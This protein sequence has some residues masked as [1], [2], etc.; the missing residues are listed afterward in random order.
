MGQQLE[1]GEILFPA[2]T[3]GD[4]GTYGSDMFAAKPSQ[5]GPF[6]MASIIENQRMCHRRIPGD[7]RN[8]HL[9]ILL[10]CCY[11][12]APGTLKTVHFLCAAGVEGAG[13]MVIAPAITLRNF[14]NQVCDAVEEDHMEEGMEEDLEEAL[15]NLRD[16]GA[17]Y[18]QYVGADGA[19]NEEYDDY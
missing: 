19:N 2:V 4:G 10:A 13:A 15:S 8:P 5:Q 6:F 12:E 9:I 14:F 11:I 16:L 3:V 7:T 18:D 17:E 1:A